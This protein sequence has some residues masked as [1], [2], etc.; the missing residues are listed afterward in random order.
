[1]GILFLAGLEQAPHTNR[2]RF[3]F[4]SLN[5]EKELCDSAFL[6][7]HEQYKNKILGDNRIETIFVRHV[8]NNLLKG[9]NDDLMTLK[10]I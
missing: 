8:M 2:W 6:A 10:N 5:E 9:L 1:F 7:V 4:M 3:R